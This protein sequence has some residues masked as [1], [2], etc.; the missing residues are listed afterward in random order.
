MLPLSELLTTVL[1]LVIVVLGFSAIIVIHELGH[2]LAARWAGIRVLA[3]AVGFGPALVSYRKGIGLRRGSSEGEYHDRLGAELAKIPNRDDHPEARRRIAETLSPTEYRLN[4][5]PL[6]G[7][8]RMLGQEDLNP[9]AISGA[10]DSYQS[11]SVPKRMV[12]IAAGVVFNLVTAALMFIAV[13]MVGLK[14]EPPVVGVVRAGSPAENAGLLTGDTV[15]SIDGAT[16]QRFDDLSMATAM[17]GPGETLSLSVLRRGEDEPRTIE[18]E[19]KPSE[20]T[21]LL[22]IGVGPAQTLRVVEP[23]SAAG[24]ARAVDLL[25]REGLPGV[26]PGMVLT[27]ATIAGESPVRPEGFADLLPVYA[28]A[29]DRAVELTFASDDGRAVTVSTRPRPELQVGLVNISGTWRAF[30]HVAGLTPLMRVA[31]GTEPEQ[32]LAP[33]DVFVRVGGAEFPSV[34]RAIHE[35]RSR[36]GQPIE[37]VVERAGTDGVPERVTIDAKVSTEGTV[38]FLL[39]DTARSDTRIALTPTIY[40]S[41]VDDTPTRMPANGFDFRAGTR[42]TEVSGR[43]VETLEDVRDVL[44]LAIGMKGDGATE[45]AVRLTL[46]PPGEGANAAY[47][48]TLVLDAAAEADITALSWVPPFSAG[49]FEPEQALLRAS[50]PVGAIGMGL[51][52]T[53]RVLASTY[54]T[55][56]RLF[57]GTVKV[58]HLKGPVGIAHIG[59]IVAGRGTV[60]LLFFFAL[61][62]VN[63]AVINFLPLPIV[64][65]GQFLMLV[66]E[67]MRGRPV[68]IGV[69][70]GLTLAGLLLIGTVFL[71]VTF[72]D[73]R[74]LLGV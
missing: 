32:G 25:E 33:G 46:V 10:S 18:V 51:H 58:E 19:P 2:F 39:D 6:G 64:D 1:D 40:S 73:V 29:G 62:S 11:V 55:F 68:P 14:V 44:R 43:P 23:T 49:V 24:R 71:I 70:N 53:K 63:L 26:E 13:F 66:Y 3:F 36:R 8:V 9:G 20:L 27:E 22:E 21:G 65:G 31:P 5:L 30:D 47:E 50:N 28:E 60:W 69:Q 35:I 42:I 34:A 67:H 52:E 37:L 38:G 16:A 72:N 54:L 41:V 7:Y 15:L 57:Q 17:A 74:S 59:T 61:I 56:A 12:V 48:Q 4:A 45:V